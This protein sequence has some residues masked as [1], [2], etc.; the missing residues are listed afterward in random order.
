MMKFAALL[1]LLCAANVAGQ[2][3]FIRS[4][5]SGTS[6]MVTVIKD[7]VASVVLNLD[8][9]GSEDVQ[10][11]A[12]TIARAV[13]EAA[14]EATANG[15]IEG[16]VT[17]GGIANGKVDVSSTSIAKAVAKAVGEAF[18]AIGGNGP[19]IEAKL[20][21]IKQDVE[22][23]IASVS[24]ELTLAGDATGTV[25]A[26]SQAKVFVK[27]IAEA[28]AEAA[29]ACKDGVGSVGGKVDAKAEIVEVADTKA[30]QVASFLDARGPGSF[31]FAKNEAFARLLGGDAGSAPVA[32]P[33][34]T[35]PTTSPSPEAAPLPTPTGATP[36]T[37][38]P[39]GGIINTLGGLISSLRP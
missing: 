8:K 35:S 13:A 24:Q 27:V 10:L 7:A 5:G 6:E 32:S 30:T 2:S 3:V 17:G 29:L 33:N 28:V 15:K 4:S 39:F 14:A 16:T 22:T 1:V 11:A 18:A 23:A 20:M 38:N 19:K 36:V 34:A 25:Q 9:C 37:G 12:S 31:A 21:A 26:A